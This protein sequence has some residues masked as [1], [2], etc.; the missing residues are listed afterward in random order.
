MS[1]RCPAA[2]F[3]GNLTAF[4]PVEKTRRG[5]AHKT[6]LVAATVTLPK[7]DIDPFHQAIGMPV[8]GADIARDPDAC[9]AVALI[10][11]EHP[12]HPSSHDDVL[13]RAALT[14]LERLVDAAGEPKST[15]RLDPRMAVRVPAEA[16]DGL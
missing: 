5:I 15:L 10:P 14:A 16:T 3:V 2:G 12:R 4:G 7:E 13:F 9:P 6:R 8:G 1:R 11:A